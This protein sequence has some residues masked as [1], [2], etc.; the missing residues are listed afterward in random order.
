MSTTRVIRFADHGRFHRAALRMSVAGALAG[1]VA[2][3]IALLEPGLGGPAAPLPLALVAGAAL[4]GAAP[5]ETRARGFDLALVV[6]A[7]SAAAFALAAA[8][9]GHMAPVLG[10]ALFAG[11]LGLLFGR[12]APHGGPAGRPFGSAPG[13]TRGASGARLW[14]LVAAGAGAALAARFVLGSLAAFEPGPAWM[15][16]ALSGGAFGAVAVLGLL[17]RHLAV[18]QR[19]RGEVDELMARAR[20]VLTASERAGDD[21]TVRE[22]I[23]GEVARLDEVAGRWRELERQVTSSPEPAALSARIQELD[24][25]IVMAADPVAR[26]QFEQAQSEVAQ[27]LRDVESMWHARERVLAR[28]HHSL[29]AIERMRT[30]AVGAEMDTASHAL[31]EAED[32]MQ[33]VD[34]RGDREL[35]A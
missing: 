35:G 16:A 34:G 21:V 18:A 6:L 3:V 22:A 8:G 32:I 27:Q 14:L 5:R 26:G 13:G 12:G 9:R 10:V 31:V 17:P 30:G 33:S 24:R 7:A 20:A 15:A 1:L 25:R 28:M 23:R 11:A 19:V 29:A 2:H 4:H